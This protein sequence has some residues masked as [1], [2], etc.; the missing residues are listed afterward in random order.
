MK[1]GVT[2]TAIVCKPKDGRGE[3]DH[4]ALGI[5]GVSAPVESD[6]SCAFLPEFQHVRTGG[7][8]LIKN[9]Y[10]V[11]RHDQGTTETR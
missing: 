1:L 11:H 3:N 10:L 7:P 4:S 2:S 8:A 9:T 6:D 5:D